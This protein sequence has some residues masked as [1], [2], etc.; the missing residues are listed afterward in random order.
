VIRRLRQLRRR[1]LPE[2]VLTGD[3]SRDFTVEDFTRPPQIVVD[4]RIVHLAA[5]L[6]G[7]TPER[8]AV[9]AEA[10][11]PNGFPI[12]F[13]RWYSRPGMDFEAFKALCLD[14]RLN[15][16]LGISY[17]HSLILSEWEMDPDESFMDPAPC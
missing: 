9:L 2:P 15:R 4:P 1:K 17:E 13:A 6:D 5:H 10:E 8:W 12:A 11:T 3:H 16:H 7:F 14:A